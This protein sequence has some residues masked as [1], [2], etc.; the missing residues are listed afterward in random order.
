M[1]CCS[2]QLAVAGSSGVLVPFLTYAAPAPV[3]IAALALV[4]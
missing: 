3:E 2:V 1:I 4:V